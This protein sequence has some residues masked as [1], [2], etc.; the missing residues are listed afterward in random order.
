M[1]Q[2]L[3]WAEAVLG[4]YI[5]LLS[6]WG[7]PLPEHIPE[8]YFAWHACYLNV[9]FQLSDSI[10]K[11]GDSALKTAVLLL[12]LAH[13]KLCQLYTSSPTHCSIRL[14]L[15]SSCPTWTQRTFTQPSISA[16]LLPRIHPALKQAVP[17]PC[18]SIVQM[19]MSAPPV[20]PNH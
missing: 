2:K 5:L 15:G 19:N 14:G 10:K 17:W 1:L 7:G 20:N 11:Q 6:S 18:C 12:S 16:P 13:L 3:L 4:L 9:I 8:M